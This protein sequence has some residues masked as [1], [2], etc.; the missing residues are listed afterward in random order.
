MKMTIVE[1]PFGECQTIDPG[2]SFQLLTTELLLIDFEI[3]EPF[4]VDASLNLISKHLGVI[5]TILLVILPKH[6][7][8][9][10]KVYFPPNCW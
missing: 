1:C 10:L 7:H 8:M 4:C 2:V 6:I 3:D 5:I 9:L